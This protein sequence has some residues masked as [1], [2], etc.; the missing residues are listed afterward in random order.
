MNT[1]PPRSPADDDLNR[2]LERGYRDTSPEFEARW[3]A[4]KRELRQR[5][6]PRPRWWT[7]WRLAGWLAIVGTAAVIAFMVFVVRPPVPSAP[8][9][10]PQLCE[11]LAMDAALTRAQPLLDEEIRSALLHLPAGDQSRN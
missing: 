5:P 3:V 7:A 6:A 9:L 8:E 1:P 10:T 4:L 11:L 2:L